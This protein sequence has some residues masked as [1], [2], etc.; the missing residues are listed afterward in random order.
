MNKENI[1]N[2]LKIEVEKAKENQEINKLDQEQLEKLSL[3][4]EYFNLH[5]R[6]CLT[7]LINFTYL[8]LTLR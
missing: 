1:F 5:P 7:F 4:S 2:R 6:D 3:I 8:S